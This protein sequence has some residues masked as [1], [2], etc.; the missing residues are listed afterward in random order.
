MRRRAVIVR[1]TS[2]P[3][4]APDEGQPGAAAPGRVLVIGNLDGVHRGHQAIVRAAV[5]VA[6]V[7]SLEP[8]VLTFDPHPSAVV[9]STAPP[10]LTSLERKAELVRRLGIVTLFARNFDASFAAWTPERFAQ[11]LLARCI[12]AKAVFVG[13][14]FRFGAGRAGDLDALRALGASA[15]FEL[16]GFPMLRDEKGELS[17]SRVRTDVAGGD[18]EDVGLT[19]GRW[20]GFA[21]KVVEGDKRGR[22]LGFPTANLAE[23]SELL[24]PNG[25]YAVAVDEVAALGAPPGRALG[26]GVM[27]IGVR[28][29]V[30]GEL[31]RTIE[32]HLFDLS[33]DLYGAWLRVHLVARL[34]D[35][36]KF[37]GLDALK[38]QIGRD[39]AEGRAK[40][41]GVVPRPDGAFG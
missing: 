23:V 25:V 16:Y 37:D 7:R 17:S 8:A 29:T 36:R 28:P 9:G 22:T 20:H 11:D 31:R 30:A 27:N 10:L 1:L 35:E 6:K 5:A 38:A 14:N 32:V 4:A 33:R 12:G 18:L 24:P 39:V 41:E 26:L 21:G 3:E 13:E 2:E 15:G 34:R 19:L 40:L